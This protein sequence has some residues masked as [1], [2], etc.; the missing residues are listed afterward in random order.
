MQ[1]KFNEILIELGSKTITRGFS[2]NR[3]VC[4]LVHPGLEMAGWRNLVTCP[5]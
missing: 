2:L 3:R 4:W 1:Q 5:E